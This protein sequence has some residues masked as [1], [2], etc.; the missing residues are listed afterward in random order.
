MNA[1]HAKLETIA[2][3]DAKRGDLNG[4]EGGAL[5]IGLLE[6]EELMVQLLDLVGEWVDLMI[7]VAHVTCHLP[8][9]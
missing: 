7:D 2:S 1:F 6:G 8:R 3:I 4:R 9:Q 5:V